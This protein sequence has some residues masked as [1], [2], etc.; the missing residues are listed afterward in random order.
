[1]DYNLWDVNDECFELPEKLRVLRYLGAGAY[2]SVCSAFDSSKQQEVLSHIFSIHTSLPFCSMRHQ[3][4]QTLLS[5]VAI[6]KC[7]NIF[8]NRTIAK[9][10][11]R[12]LRLLRLLSHPNI[13]EMISILPITQTSDFNDIYI[14]FE[15]METDLANIIKSKQTLI[16]AHV[17]I[18]MYQIISALNYLHLSHV[19]HRDLKP[20][21]ILV[22]S[23]CL[24]K[25]ADFGLART[26]TF[27]DETKT[28]PMTEY[29]T[30][31]WY[32]APEVLVGWHRYSSSVDM[33]AAGVILAELITR[34]PVF[35]GHDA[36][37]QM[38][39]IV[40]RLGLPS[41]S[42]IDACRKRVHRQRLRETPH[43]K[44]RIMWLKT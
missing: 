43:F 19:V 18:F 20:R 8:T 3:S 33:W 36:L 38:D 12:E 40:S 5:K 37:S 17:Q 11:L 39:M 42:F 34:H 10:T 44:V 21:N 2:G 29:V 16:D 14:V 25:V 9:R 35:P 22:N 24:L 32:R 7:K 23:N 6:K 41:Q 28:T 1:M 4:D 30:S 13:I 26:T 31:R 27:T 15:V